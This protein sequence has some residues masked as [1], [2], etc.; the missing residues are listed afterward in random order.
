MGQRSG[1]IGHLFSLYYEKDSTDLF[2]FTIC[3]GEVYPDFYREAQ[4]EKQK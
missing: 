1:D 3:E 4:E 2:V